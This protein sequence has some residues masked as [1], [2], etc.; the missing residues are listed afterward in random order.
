M[1]VW[2]A[3]SGV[4]TRCS[5]TYW[6]IDILTASGL[7][8][9]RWCR[10]LGCRVAAVWFGAICCRSGH[11]Q[12]RIF[13]RVQGTRRLLRP[14]T[15]PS[16]WYVGPGTTISLLN[17]VR[18]QTQRSHHAMQLQEKTTGVT[19]WLAFRVSSPQRR[20]LGETVRTRGRS[21][22]VVPI[23]GSCLQVGG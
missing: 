7:T 11:R 18:L 20:C 12:G 13:A 2:S 10:Y 22:S 21:I 19:Q 5:T 17:H 6:A 15:A 23:A 8:S 3:S 14:R 16:N 9:S 4:G 1:T